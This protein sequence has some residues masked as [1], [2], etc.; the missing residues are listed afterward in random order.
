[1]VLKRKRLC[2]TDSFGDAQGVDFNMHRVI[3][4]AALAATVFGATAAQAQKETREERAAAAE[5]RKKLG[6]LYLRCDGE[7]NNMTGGESFARLLGALTLL[8]IFAPAPESPDPS[9]RL[10]GEAGVDACNQL[11][12][13]EKAEGNAV[14]RVPLILARALHQIEARNYEAALLDVEKARGEAA[15]A[16]LAGNPY[17]DRSMGLSFSTIEAEARLRLGDAEGAN[18]ASLAPLKGVTYSFVPSI[19]TQDYSEY[20]RTLTPAAEGKAASNARMLPFLLDE[21]ADKLEEVDRFA[22]AATKREALITMVEGLKPENPSSIYYAQA[23]LAHALAGQWDQAD[24]R[25]AFA[26]S[27]MAQRRADGVPE[28][29]AAKVVEVL[30]LYAILKTAHDGDLIAARRLFSGRSQWVEPSFGAVR[31]TNRLLREGATEAE[32]VGPLAVLPEEMWQSRYDDLMAVKLQKDSDNKTLFQFIQPYAKVG[33]FEARTKDTWRIQKSKMMAKEADEDGFWRIW[34]AGDLYTGID[35]IMLHAA[36]QAKSRGKDGFT[37]LIVLP[38]KPT[39]YYYQLVTLGFTRF[40]DEG[41]QGADAA[42]FIPAQAVIDELSPMIPSPE[43]LKAR[44]A[45]RK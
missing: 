1:M 18:E 43:E 5:E 27:N 20:V 24:A 23:A 14:R 44:K 21:Y 31:Q 36:L 6:S 8:S 3:A 38:S 41:E 9:K 12:D 17:F 13:G 40:V 25:A 42:L 26:R 15:A 22:D 30:D 11:I 2:A 28:E 7:P 45:K 34:A 29:D 35:S 10:F 16:G 19:V 32:L 39:G 4:A 33:E 37:M